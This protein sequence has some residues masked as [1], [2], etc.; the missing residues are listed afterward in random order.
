MKVYISGKITGV[1][2]DIATAKFQQAEQQVM[3]YG[4]EPVNPMKNGIDASEPWE[5]HMAADVP[6]LLECEAIYL[7]TDWS[8]SKGARIEANIAQECGMEIMYQ[9]EYGAYT[10]KL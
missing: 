4:Y 7:L 10:S 1:P 6:M 9:P 8:D 5:K 2:V 3:A